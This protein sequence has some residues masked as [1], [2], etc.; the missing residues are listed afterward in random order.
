MHVIWNTSNYCK[1]SYTHTPD[2]KALVHKFP[3][4]K[5][6]W[7]SLTNAESFWR[8]WW[9]WF[10]CSNI[11]INRVF[12]SNDQFECISVHHESYLTYTSLGLNK[13]LQDAGKPNILPQKYANCCHVLIYMLLLTLYA[14]SCSHLRGINWVCSGVSPTRPSTHRTLKAAAESR[15]LSGTRYV[16]RDNNHTHVVTLHVEIKTPGSFQVLL[17]W[18]FSQLTAKQTCLW[19]RVALS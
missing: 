14:W 11:V 12:N 3:L 17:Y 8:K 15:W 6:A 7:H 1:L 18:E 4:W 9:W 16:D 10:Y 13:G 5:S 19:M 2:V